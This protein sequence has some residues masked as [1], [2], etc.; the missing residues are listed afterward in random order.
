MSIIN[1]YLILYN[2]VQLFGWTLFFSKVTLDL[3]K[4]KTIPE[5]YEDTHV[6][7]QF[8]QYGASLEIL[9]SLIKLVKSSVFATSI[10]I[11][12][13]MAIVAILQYFRSSVS[14]GYLLLYFAWSL[15]EMIRY[16][17]YIFKIIKSEH[18]S[19][20][21]PYWLVW[22]RYSFFIVLYPIGVSGEM[23]T[24]WHARKDLQ[25]YNITTSYTVADLVYP[26]YVLYVPPLI[27]LYSYLFKQR[28]KEL[29]KVNEEKKIKKQ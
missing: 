12:G 4:S 27:F 9:H 26:I 28:N 24:I 19:F 2:S 5:I 23:I 7:L 10:Q 22:C 16:P 25:N 15:V 14:F 1:L 13:R 3:I 17:Y 11:L 20:D 21:V 8:C 29:K 6:I 18:K